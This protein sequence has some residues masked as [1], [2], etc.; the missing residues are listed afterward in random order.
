MRCFVRGIKEG[1]VAG[2][3]STE[4]EPNQCFETS[5]Q[6]SPLDHQVGDATARSTRSR[7]TQDRP[8]GGQ[9]TA[10]RRD[11]V[12]R[13]DRGLILARARRTGHLPSLDP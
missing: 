5:I 10:M 12:L 2:Q 6:Y 11:D 7:T 13:E 1:L 4:T 8:A 3:I 9:N